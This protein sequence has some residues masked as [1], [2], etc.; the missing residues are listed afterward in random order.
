MISIV[1][2]T[3]GAWAS[4]TRRAHPSVLLDDF[5]TVEMYPWFQLPTLPLCGAALCQP[6]GLT[7]I[8]IKEGREKLV[9]RNS[10]KE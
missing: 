3:E 5:P 8:C 6:A 9:K 10:N 2:T 1:L 7:F 4:Q